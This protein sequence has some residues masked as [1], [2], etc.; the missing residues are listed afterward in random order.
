MGAGYYRP[1]I[2]WSKGEYTTANNRQDDVAAIAARAPYRTDEAGGTLA[3]AST[4]TTGTKYITQATDQDLYLL[5]TC[6]GSLTVSAATP[7]PATPSPNLDIKLELLDSAGTVVASNDPP[8]AMVSAETAS[9]LSASI[10]Q[11]VTG[12]SYFLRVD[13][14]GVGTPQTGYSDY[15]SIGA[16]A[17]TVSGGVCTAPTGAPAAPLNVVATGNRPPGPPR[18]LGH[19]G[20]HRWRR[21]DGLQRLRQRGSG[22]HVHGSEHDPDRAGARHAV[23]RVG[24][25]G[26][27][28]RHMTPGTR[29][30]VH[31]PRSPRLRP[32]PRPR[33]ARRVARRPPPSPGPHRPAPAG[34]RSPA[35]R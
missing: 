4:T 24:E 6:T 14:V 18:Q 31:P 30:S 19:T 5:G 13:G 35:I 25:R 2:Q 33:A 34:C 22:D 7:A 21:R 9:G 29:R 27:R 23:R 11:A 8:S 1:V 15:G 28:V 17:L 3:T 12:G 16:Y 20:Q 10:T 26:Q 32:S